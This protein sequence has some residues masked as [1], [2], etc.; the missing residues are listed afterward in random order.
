MSIIESLC[1]CS[2]T[3]V[4]FLK[5]VSISSLNFVFFVSYIFTKLSWENDETIV[6][7]SVVID[8]VADVSL[9][10]VIYLGDDFFLL[11][12]TTGN[13]T[14]FSMSYKALMWRLYAFCGGLRNCIVEM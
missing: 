11:L 7:S 9:E 1:A 2:C 10:S 6:E 5:D 8:A 13:D 3:A 14:S 12:S 4:S